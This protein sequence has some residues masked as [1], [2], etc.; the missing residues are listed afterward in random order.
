VIAA[1][2][3]VYGRPIKLFSRFE[4]IWS[5]ISRAVISNPVVKKKMVTSSC[6]LASGT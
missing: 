5:N 2:T 3:L 1:K 6:T 4:S